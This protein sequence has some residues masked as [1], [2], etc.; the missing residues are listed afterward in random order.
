MGNI[1]F[2]KGMIFE[3]RFLFPILINS[4]NRV[5]IISNGCYY[6]RQHQNQTTRRD[7]DSYYL[8]GMILSD[9]NILNNMPSG[10]KNIYAVLY[11]RIV[12]NLLILGN[13]KNIILPPLN[14][15]IQDL[16]SNKITIGIRLRLSFFKLFGFKFYSI[17]FK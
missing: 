14:L 11:Y 2:P 8:I 9:I 15:S 17:I 13:N 1:R 7:K 3:D 10:L 4:C 5:S 6:Y 12:S 16:W